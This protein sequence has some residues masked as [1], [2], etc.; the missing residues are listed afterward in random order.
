MGKQLQMAEKMAPTHPHPHGPEGALGNL[1][2]RPFVVMVDKVR[3]AL[4]G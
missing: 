2:I 3:D 4:K 1:V